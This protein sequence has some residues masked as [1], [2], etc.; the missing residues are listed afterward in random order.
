M[1][2]IHTCVCF[3]STFPHSRAYNTNVLYIQQILL[4]P[5]LDATVFKLYFGLRFLI[6]YL[7][8]LSYNKF[9]NAL[10]CNEYLTFCIFLDLC[11]SRNHVDVYTK[12][13]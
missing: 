9:I 1:E 2:E 8:Y 13:Y 4:I 5:Y 3:P 10:D 12:A 7:D 6:V 11:V